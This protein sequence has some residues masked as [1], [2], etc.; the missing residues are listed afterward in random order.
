[1]RSP[2]SFYLALVIPMVLTMTSLACATSAAKPTVTLMPTF[3]PSPTVE[4]TI[5]LT[6]LPVPEGWNRTET[7]D[8]KV[9][10]A[11]PPEWVILEAG[12]DA[13]NQTVATV[14]QSNAEVSAMLEKQL[15]LAIDQKMS[16]FALDLAPESVAQ[17]YVTNM[18][19]VRRAFDVDVTLDEFATINHKSVA[20]AVGEESLT[21]N[22]RSVAGY[23][24]GKFSYG[25]NAQITETVNRDLQIVQYFLLTDSRTAYMVS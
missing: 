4:A 25:A 24:G 21:E 10:I 15:A 13:A 19:I 16:L 7:S 2:K 3:G 22:R 18:N 20:K 14:A 9:S 11:I 17:G 1:M 12:T 5:T 8:G 6:P 23:S